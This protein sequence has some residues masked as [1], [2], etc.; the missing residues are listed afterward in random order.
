MPRLVRWP[1]FSALK[2]SRSDGHPRLEQL[3]QALGFAK[4]HQESRLRISQDVRLA[5]RIFRDPVRAKWRI[6][7]HGNSAGQQN[8]GEGEKKFR[9]KSAA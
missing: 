5:R 9:A 2:T 1:S 8:P 3:R 7:R 4:R 6:D